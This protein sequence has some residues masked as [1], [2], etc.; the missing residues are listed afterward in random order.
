MKLNKLD[1]KL[2]E[3]ITEISVAVRDINNNLTYI[4]LQ[5]GYLQKIVNDL[6]VAKK[7][8]EDVNTAR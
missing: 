2:Q 8:I 4:E 5:Q 6:E 7:V 1:S 3:I